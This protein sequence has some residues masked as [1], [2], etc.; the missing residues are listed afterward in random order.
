MVDSREKGKRG[1]YQVR[2]LF[3]KHTGLPWERVPGSGM[4]GAQHAL[5]GDIYVPETNYRHCVE[6]KTYATDTINCNL[7]NNSKSQLETFWEQCSR[8]AGQIN[9]EPILVFKK[10]RGKWIV[11]TEDF[12]VLDYSDLG[13]SFQSSLLGTTL[14]M[15]LLEDWFKKDRKY[16][17]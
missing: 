8:E 9:K 17:L 1:E 10:D 5:K 12:E 7:L 15:V 6:I 14:F 11:A 13:M 2:D 4:F 16:V 3:R